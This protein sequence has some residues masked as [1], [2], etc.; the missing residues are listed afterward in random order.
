MQVSKQT[1]Y[2]VCLLTC[3]VVNMDHGVIPACTW[4]LK[5]QLHVEDLFIGVLGSLVF[6]GLMIGAVVR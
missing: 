5:S 1:I 4:E 6:A 3:V 2:A